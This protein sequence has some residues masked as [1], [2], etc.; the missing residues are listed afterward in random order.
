M[1][2]SAEAGQAKREQLEKILRAR[3]F[4]EARALPNAVAI[5]CRRGIQLRKSSS[6][7]R[8]HRH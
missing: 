2:Q 5:S 7:A 3:R 6:A 4:S 8:R 1:D